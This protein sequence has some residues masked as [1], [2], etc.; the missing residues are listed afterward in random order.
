MNVLKKAGRFFRAQ[1]FPAAQPASLRSLSTGISER[2]WAAPVE[3]VARTQGIGQDQEVPVTNFASEDKGLAVL[4]GGVFDVPIRP[5]IVQRVVLWQLN[6]RRQGTH[7][8]KGRHDVSG[9]TRKPHSQKGSGQARQGSK[10]APHMRGG[11]IAHGPRP[12]SHETDLP[13][14]VRQLGLRVALSA[15]MAEGKLLV[16]DTLEPESAK[17]KDMEL[18]LRRLGQSG[19]KR[20]LFVD[21]GSAAPNASLL[22]A[23]SNLYEANVLPPIGLNVYSILQHDTLIL[24][25]DAVRRIEE[26]LTP[27]PE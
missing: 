2:L 7:S 12:R 14:Q 26:R 20:V 10:K 15:R 21:G 19:A 1:S 27:T 13:K 18:F 24:A 22:R 3:E 9:S 4:A 25:L 5:D 6:K 17:T 16:F 8:T 23:T 11:A